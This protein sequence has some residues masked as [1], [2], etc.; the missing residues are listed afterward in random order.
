MASHGG[1]LLSDE[2]FRQATDEQLLSLVAKLDLVLQSRKMSGI[3]WREPP[4]LEPSDPANPE[5]PLR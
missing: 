5:E 3:E 2:D 4:E 1:E